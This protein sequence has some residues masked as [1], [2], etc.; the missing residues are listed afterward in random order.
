MGSARTPTARRSQRLRVVFPD[1]VATARRLVA[2][3]IPERTVYNRCRDGGPW[4][5]LLPGVVL[6]SNGEPSLDQ[7]VRAALLFGGPLTLL[8]GVEACRRHGLRRGP[9]RSPVPRG[10]PTISILVPDSRQL[11]STGFVEV[12]RTGRM[13][14]P[15]VRDGVP[16]APIVRACA[17][18]V[19]GLESAAEMTE[20]MSDAVQ[21][22]LCTVAALAGELAE[23]SRR[24][25]ATPAEVL[26]DVADGVRSTA[27]R[28]A[29]RLWARS[30]LPEPWWNAPVHA[31]DGR[32][33][34]K[35]DCWLDDV[36]MAW[37][38]ESSEWHLSPADHDYTVDRAARFTSAGVVYLASKPKKIL[39]SGPEVL[40]VL[41][42][43]YAHA[44]SR[45]R[46]A[47]HAVDPRLR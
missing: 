4:R 24:L 30:G 47:V 26:R 28:D 16:L 34:G 43:A 31:P 5:R 25:T 9:A 46:P 38:I 14:P 3:G 35:A 42:A 11:R 15:H 37:E 27:E 20:L 39:R 18:A 7:L 19:R 6:L 33:L 23:G 12:S 44:A 45:P 8:T 17:D 21:R 40:E 32:L 10:R 22:G 29:K 41:R 1:G 2:A 13:P 36:A